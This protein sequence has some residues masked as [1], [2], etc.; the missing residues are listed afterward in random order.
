MRI[1]KGFGETILTGCIVGF[2][3]YMKK[4][5]GPILVLTMNSFCFLYLFIIEMSSNMIIII[6]TLCCLYNTKNN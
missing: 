1:Y 6:L 4:E 5:K 3:H 2:N